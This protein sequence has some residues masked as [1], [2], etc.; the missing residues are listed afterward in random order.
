[1]MI[2]VALVVGLGSFIIGLEIGFYLE[3]KN[4]LNNLQD[5]VC[6]HCEEKD[7]DNGD[8]LIIYI[9]EDCNEEEE[10]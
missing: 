7:G 1:M 2:F 8:Y 10:E 3:N 5:T 4:L 9:C 6:F